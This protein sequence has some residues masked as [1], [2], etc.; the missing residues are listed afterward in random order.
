MRRV[1]FIHRLA[2]MLG[3]RRAIVLPPDHDPTMRRRPVTLIDDG[4]EV[5]AEA[6]FGLSARSPELSA[7]TTLMPRQRRPFAAVAIVIIVAMV[8]APRLTSIALIT[9]ATLLYLAALAFRLQLVRVSLDAPALVVVD[10]ER[11]RSIP[12]DDL[13]VYT[14]LVPLYGEPTVAAGL[15]AALARL[16]YPADRLDIKVLLEEDDVPTIEA[17]ALAHGEVDLEL[18]VVPA[19]GP[20]TKPKACNVGLAMAR[21]EFV[22]IYDAEDRPDPLQLRRA[23]AAF[24]DDPSTSCLQALLSYY[25]PRQNVLTRWFTI[26][27]AVWFRMLLPGLAALGAPIPLG[28]TSN[29]IR[30]TVLDELGGWDP[31]NV[32][33]DADLGI[34]LHRANR[35]VR[36]LDSVTLEEAN[37]DAINWVKQRSRWYKGY[38]QTWLVHMRSPRVLRRQLGRGP[39]WAFNLFVG[40]TPL[41]SLL[42]PVFW[43]LTVLWFVDEP[44]WIVSIFPA[45]VYYAGLLCWTIGNLAV[46]YT[47]L[48][49]ARQSSLVSLAWVVPLSPFYWLLMAAAAIKAAIQLVRKPAYWEKTRHGLTSPAED[50]WTS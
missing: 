14:V 6:A 11:A 7:A 20:Q 47:N 42:N 9:A 46:V 4:S 5:L 30:K 39:F 43:I 18:L 41:L 44:E 3:L 13:P 40:G 28:G 19:V 50:L 36:V 34:R 23:V 12:D 31:H 15:V 29:H 35:S 1:P 25:N 22:T 49:A 26:E 45:P 32:T 10:D 38:L 2:T 27:Y 17:V 8:A 33:E 24:R 37:S 48:V 21:G 16:E